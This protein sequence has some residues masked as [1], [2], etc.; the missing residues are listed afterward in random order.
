MTRQNFGTPRMTQFSSDNFGV[1][2]MHQCVTS[3][4]KHEHWAAHKRKACAHHFA[5]PAAALE[6]ALHERARANPSLVRLL[7]CFRVGLRDTG[8]RRQRAPLSTSSD[9]ADRA[10]RLRT[11]QVDPLASD[12]IFEENTLEFSAA[13]NTFEWFADSRAPLQRVVDS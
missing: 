1:E 12:A 4:L 8:F 7:C 5:H 9:Q 3:A 13:V 11:L 6:A 10:E 2:R